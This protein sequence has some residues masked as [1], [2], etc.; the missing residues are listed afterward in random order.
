[1]ED[2][3]Y[4]FGVAGAVIRVHMDMIKRQYPL[5]VTIVEPGQRLLDRLNEWDIVLT[6]VGSSPARNVRYELKP[7]SGVYGDELSTSKKEI[8]LLAGNGARERIEVWPR[9]ATAP[10]I[11]LRLTWSDDE[12]SKEQYSEIVV[13]H[14]EHPFALRIR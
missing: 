2:M 4:Y 14:D 8:P 5:V 9:E 7:A 13:G 11:S 12:G 1:M 10:R 3:H 6:N